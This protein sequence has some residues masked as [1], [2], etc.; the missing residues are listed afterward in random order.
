MKLRHIP[1]NIRAKGSKDVPDSE[2]KHTTIVNPPI[3][4]YHGRED[5]FKDEHIQN[6]Y[7]EFHT[8]GNLAN[9]SN[10]RR[11]FKGLPPNQSLANFELA[12]RNNTFTSPQFSKQSFEGSVRGVDKKKFQGSSNVIYKK[13]STSPM[14]R[15]FCNKKFESFKSKNIPVINKFNQHD[16]NAFFNT[17]DNFN[18]EITQ[19]QSISNNA[20]S[21]NELKAYNSEY[22]EK[23]FYVPNNIHKYSSINDYPVYP[24]ARTVGVEALNKLK[25]HVTRPIKYEIQKIDYN[26]QKIFKR[27]VVERQE[28]S[29]LSG[30][31]HSNERYDKFDNKYK[32]RNINNIRHILSTEGNVVRSFVSSSYRC[33]S[34]VHDNRQLIT[35]MSKMFD[36]DYLAKHKYLSNLERR[37]IKDRIKEM[38]SSLKLKARN[39]DSYSNKEFTK[40]SSVTGI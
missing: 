34:K 2:K 33:N 30:S 11:V 36:E 39:K 40:V 12:L 25:N 38:Q 6:F 29:I 1:D 20:V 5:K 15:L 35:S 16:P 28:T 23:P 37:D 3:F 8:K 4:H 9:T 14:S 26:G 18:D 22:R 24:E 13:D 27:G 7:T 32:E 10:E 19:T 17:K 31:H 21:Y